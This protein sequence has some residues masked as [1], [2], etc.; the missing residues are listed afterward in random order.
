MKWTSSACKTWDWAFEA[1]VARGWGLGLKQD[2]WTVCPQVPSL[3][4]ELGPWVAPPFLSLQNRG[5]CWGET[6]YAG[7]WGSSGNSGVWGWD[8]GLKTRGLN[9]NPPSILW[10]TST[11]FSCSDSRMSRDRC[12]CSVLSLYLPHP[13]STLEDLSQEKGH[14]DLDMWWPQMHNSLK[15]L[16]PY[17]QTSESSTTLA[18]RTMLTCK[19]GSQCSDCNLTIFF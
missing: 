10:D 11:P 12:N 3:P 14:S 5:L 4:G 2:W 19:H 8:T 17:R 6:V 13:D 1:Q 18:H 16:S 9:E 15:F 7:L